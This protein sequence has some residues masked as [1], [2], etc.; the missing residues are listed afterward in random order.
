MQD[1]KKND[2]F[3]LE[4]KIKGNNNQFRLDIWASG[5]HD[6][7]KNSEFIVLILN[8]DEYN[9]FEN[10]EDPSDLKSIKTIKNEHDLSGCQSYHHASIVL[11]SSEKIYILI[12]NESNE[13]LDVGVSYYYSVIPPTYYLGLLIAAIGISFTLILGIFY[14]SNWKRF[15]FIGTLINTLAFILR[16]ATLSTFFD[17][18]ITPI[19]S[20]LTVEMYS[21]Y[22]AWYMGWSNYFKYGTWLYPYNMNGYVYGPLFTLTIGPFSFLPN[23]WGMGIPLFAFGIA[24]GYLVFK[25]IY[26]LTENEK[27]ASIG[28]LIYFLNPFT[29]C[30]SS[31]L[32]LNPSFFTFFVTLSFYLLFKNR[33]KG[34]L[35]SLG[36]ATMYKQFAA[37]FFPLIIIYIIKDS[38]NLKF[39]KKVKISVRYAIPYALTILLISLPFLVI[40]YQNYIYRV[41]FVN[42]FF[43]PENLNY[44]IYCLNYPIRFMDLIILIGGPNNITLVMSYLIAFY[45]LLGLCFSWIYI[46]FLRLKTR[47][48]DSNYSHQLLIHALFSSIFLI[49]SVQLFYPRGT[50][51]FY[52]ILLAPFISIFYDN[53]DLSFKQVNCLKEEKFKPRYLIPLVFSWGIFFCYRYVY[54]LIIIFWMVFLIYMYRR[55]KYMDE[56][57]LKKK[58]LKSI[59]EMNL[60]E[61]KN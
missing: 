56:T 43:N 35:I 51:K 10:G 13:S 4:P 21:D 39:F 12:I 36:I 42:S 18:P 30:Y 29:L 3:F 32:W 11:D 2:G 24:T 17:I 19:T 20:V 46:H 37:I 14:Y 7:S 61:S 27:R 26:K 58:N 38:G 59:L 31:F 15:F 23:A 16:I 5:F 48:K 28:M 44:V 33:K 41:I 1:V 47:L 55:Y 52:L 57:P 45:I 25:I 53:H 49:L 60:N 9:D 54:F 50:Y 34:S 22:Q 8:M 6:G 40:N